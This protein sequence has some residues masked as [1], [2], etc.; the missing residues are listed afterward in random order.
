MP[1]A[2]L[3]AIGFATEAT[4]GT[5]VA[6][7][8]YVPGKATLNPNQKS[9][10]P[11]QSRAVRGQVV[12]T[13]I[14]HEAAVA[15]TG[16][17]IPEGQSKLVAAAFGTGSDTKSV[18][19]TAITHPLTLQ[20]ALPSLSV[21][22]DVDVTSQILA[23]LVV[24]CMVDM[25][26]FKAAQQSLATL[27]AQFKGIRETTPATPGTPSNASPTISALQPMDF[28]LIASTY[29]GGSTSQLQDVTIGLNNKVQPVFGSN[30]KLYAVRMVP[31]SREVTLSTLLDFLDLEFYTDWIT[32]TQTQGSG[33]VVT[34]TSPTNIPGSS[35]PYSVQFTLPQL[36]PT[37]NWQQGEAAE[38]INQTLTWS[39]TGNGSNEISSVWKNSENVNLA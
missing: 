7:T 1:I 23:R 8:T 22:V 34:L 3:E 28:S 29:K 38:V 5:F 14:G 32:G 19:G 6:P 11:S 31:T 13:I 21:E 2:P 10:R 18:S 17:L 9:A 27:E 12:D 4:A 24:G 33:L 15:Y 37:G 20:N 39:A 16:E 30:G 36:R 35:T 26:T 25:L